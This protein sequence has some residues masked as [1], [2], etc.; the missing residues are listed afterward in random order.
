[1]T[2]TTAAVRSASLEGDRRF[3]T[4]LKMR[5]AAGSPRRRQRVP[6]P[7]R[8]RRRRCVTLQAAF[9][10]A[11]RKS[12]NIAAAAKSAGIRPAQHCR[13]LAASPAYWEKFTEVQ[14]DVTG[15]L[16]DRVVELATEGRTIPVLYR[17]RVC[18][19]FQRPSPRLLLFYLKA[20]KPETWGR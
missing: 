8:Q 14:Q 9:L 2:N 10:A 6:K 20:V 1:M 16:E 19:T 15:R 12:A 7:R 4:D 18:G 11:Y 5:R 3:E 17:G 13:W